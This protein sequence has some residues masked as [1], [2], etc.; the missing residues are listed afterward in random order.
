MLLSSAVRGRSSKILSPPYEFLTD[1]RS[2][3][4]TTLSSALQSKQPARSRPSSPASSRM[5]ALLSLLFRSALKV[6]PSLPTSKGPAPPLSSSAT[7]PTPAWSEL[8]SSLSAYSLLFAILCAIGARLPVLVRSC[9][10]STST[11]LFTV[12][13]PG[14]TLRPLRTAPSFLARLA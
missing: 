3:P 2:A 4:G 8:M 14:A 13:L 1:C 10:T 12:C 6:T 5:C 9:P 7:P 11:C